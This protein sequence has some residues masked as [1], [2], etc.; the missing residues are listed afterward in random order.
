[1]ATCQSQD[2]N[3]IANEKIVQ[4]LLDP[5]EEEDELGQEHY[6]IDKL[7]DPKLVLLHRIYFA[8]S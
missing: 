1:M 3:E 7:Y 4:L 5:T 6:Q 8:E 2:R